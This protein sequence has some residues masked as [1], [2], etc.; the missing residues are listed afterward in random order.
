MVDIFDEVD[1]ELRADRAQA[2]LKRYGGVL[3][4][5]AV[6]VVVATGG[7]QGWRW[8]QAKQAREAGEAYMA[9]LY[10]AEAL[11]PQ[12]SP[13]NRAEIAAKL[14][15]TAAE[16]PAGYSALARLRAAGLRAQAGD[17]KGAAALA[18]IVAADGSVDQVLRDYATL[19]VVQYGIDSTDAATQGATLQARLQPLLNPANPWHGLA[20]EAQAMLALRQGQTEQARQALQELVKDVTAPEGARARASALLSRVGE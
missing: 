10:E 11:T 13:A 16:A 6:A 18:E 19:L 3:I 4:G 5:L 7:W 15:K 20:R 2:L 9:V 14:E 8:W 1:E 17:Q 12:S